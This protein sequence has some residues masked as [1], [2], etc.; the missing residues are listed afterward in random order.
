M[1]KAVKRE[2]KIKGRQALA[3]FAREQGNRSPPH[4][5]DMEIENK[6]HS[7]SSGLESWAQSAGGRPS[8]RPG[9]WGE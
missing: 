5:F 4:E 1:A 9:H 7:T 2:K 3:T 6:S 8:C